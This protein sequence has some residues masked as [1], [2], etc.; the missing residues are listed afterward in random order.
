MIKGKASF[1][2]AGLLNIF[3]NG[4]SRL[5]IL[6]KDYLLYFYFVSKGK[7]TKEKGND[8]GKYG[9]VFYEEVSKRN[10]SWE[11]QWIIKDDR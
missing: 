8:S 1:L 10:Y 9:A 2:I 5:E 11:K 7:K 3:G 4:V 6:A